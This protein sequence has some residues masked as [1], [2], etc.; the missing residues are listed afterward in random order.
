MANLHNTKL[1]KERLAQLEQ[2]ARR[3]GVVLVPA[4]AADLLAERIIAVAHQL[5]VT[6][7]TALQTYITPHVIAVMAEVLGEH[8]A[9]LREM[10]TEA[11]PMT[12]TVPD[13][14][15]VLAALGMACK[16]ATEQ[17]GQA[18]ADAAGVLTDAADAIVGIGAQLRTN[19]SGDQPVTIG[20]RTLVYSR[21]VLIR[22]IEALD[23]GRWQCPCSEPHSPA[24][25]PCSLI[26]TLKADLAVVGGWLAGAHEQPGNER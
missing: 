24:G 18:T 3:Q 19:T 20:G 26:M 5:G 16:L 11:E 25:T 12:L 10:M 1:F 22:A 13:A 8:A 7:R 21:T 17:I 14:G 6:E 23:R 15:R 2:A 4:E 9:T